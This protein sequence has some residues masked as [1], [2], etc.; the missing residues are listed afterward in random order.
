MVRRRTIASAQTIG[1]LTKQ[2]WK[3]WSSISSHE[4]QMPMA[5]D[6]QP[7]MQDEDH[8]QDDEETGAGFE[9][10]AGARTWLVKLKQL[11][12]TGRGNR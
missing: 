6:S 3:I 1:S 7:R 10:G 8:D 9:G 12:P 2:E 5:C 11:I 4:D